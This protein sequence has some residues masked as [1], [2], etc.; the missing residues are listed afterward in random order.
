MGS[1]KH[2]PKFQWLNNTKGYFLLI[3]QTNV[4]QAIFL[5]LIIMPPGLGGFQEHVKRKEVW[6]SWDAFKV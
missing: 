6:T 4:D 5:N 3:S 2:T 1:N